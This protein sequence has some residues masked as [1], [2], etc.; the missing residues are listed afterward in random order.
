LIASLVRSKISHKAV[1]SPI[2]LFL[3]LQG[4]KL[5]FDS[6]DKQK[7]DE[8]V[9][10]PSVNRMYNI[11][12]PNDP[13]AYRIEPLVDPR[14]SRMP[15]Y[16]IDYTKGGI[17]QTLVGIS[18]LKDNIVE[19][20]Q[21]ILTGFAS[22]TADM[23]F[24]A[25]ISTWFHGQVSNKD[26]DLQRNISSAEVC[27]QSFPGE[28]STS[29]FDPSFRLDFVLYEGII[30]NPY[31]SALSVHM[32]YWNEQDTCAFILNELYNSGDLERRVKSSGA[33]KKPS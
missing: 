19:K 23:V 11:F 15:S 6:D 32:A 2:G 22:S 12:H 18:S 28:I 29:S 13:V 25:T 7:Q 8:N 1:G 33:D 30:E 16:P 17:T 14:Y 31:L 9:T 4:N 3:L 10:R 27:D 26:I 20:T 21:N 24:Q 5:S